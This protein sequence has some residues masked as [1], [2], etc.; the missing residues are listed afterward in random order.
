MV[1][2][3]GTYHC[4]PCLRQK[5]PQ[6]FDLSSTLL[7]K[8]NDGLSLNDFL[9]KGP[10]FINS[11]VNVLAA[12]RWNEVAFTGDVRK[13]FNQI[14][15][16]PDDQVYHRFLCRSKTS[17][18]PTVYQWLKLNFGDK[19]A[20]DVATNAIN[21]QAKLSQAEFPEAAK[22]A[23]DHVYVDDIGG[24]RETTAKAK[25]ITND[26]DAIL[27]KGHFQIKTWHS[28]QAEIDQFNGA[29]F[30][31]LL[32]LRWD[33]HT[34]KFTFKKN[35]LSQLDLLTK[36]RCLRLVGQIWDPVGLVLPVAI[37]FRIDLQELWSSRY[38][39]DEILPASIQSKWME[40]VQTVN[41][42]LAFEFDRKLKPSHAVGV[43]QV[44]GFCDGGEKAY[45]AVIFLRW[46]LKNGSYKCVP[47]LIKSFVAPL[48]KKTIPR[49]EL[50][51]CLTLARMFDT[52]TTSLQTSKIA[53]ETSG[54]IPLPSYLG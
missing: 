25:Q 37:K 33:K 6:R 29:R 40:N 49:L 5:G 2:R 50:M 35:E 44:H 26:I 42:L 41:H 22:E 1:N 7:Q 53:I 23:Q 4:K 28:N 27:E 46:E 31:D 3:N 9:E 30:T 10:N 45:G 19:P 16:H 39:W 11:L 15:V 47:V 48:K 12:W 54:W 24:S 36:R 17:D 18:S 8:V 52:C 20:P 14:L 38:N 32:G 43:L 34:D 51:G 21:T 13:M